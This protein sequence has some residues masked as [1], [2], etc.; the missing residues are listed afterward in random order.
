VFARA[1]QL[2]VDLVR[3]SLEDV[4]AR[5]RE[6]VLP[7]LADQ[8]GFLGVYALSTPEGRGLLLTFWE[9]AAQADAGADNGWY[10]GVLSEFVTFFRAPPGRETYEVRVA[11]PPTV[12]TA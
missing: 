10:A 2:E 3:V 9:T 11:I 6:S 5:F 8:P 7:R 1:T 4:L 12:R